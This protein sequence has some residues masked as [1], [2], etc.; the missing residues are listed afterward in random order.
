MVK[1]DIQSIVTIFFMIL[2]V[3]ATRED[4]KKGKQS[5]NFTLRDSQRERDHETLPETALK[6]TDTSLAW[7]PESKAVRQK[8]AGQF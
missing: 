7:V 1:A 5:I 6:I 3:N 8:T 2:I 4:K